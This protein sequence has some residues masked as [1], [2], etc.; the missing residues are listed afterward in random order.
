MSC[1]GIP[2]LFPI[3]SLSEFCIPFSSMCIGW[4]PSVFLQWVR[5]ERVWSSGGNSPK[6]SQRRFKLQSTTRD[7]QGFRE[8]GNQN[9]RVPSFKC[10]VPPYGRTYSFVRKKVYTPNTTGFGS[11]EW[12]TLRF[13]VQEG[14]VL[15]TYTETHVHKG[16][17]WPSL[18]ISNYVVL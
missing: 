15:E 14:Q 16:T 8:K 11:I 2:F 12:K 13:Q 1:C 9:D 7:S 3:W 18:C 5:R 4:L 17:L 10:R 6:G